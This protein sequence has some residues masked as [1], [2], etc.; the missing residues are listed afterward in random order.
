MRYFSFVCL[1]A[2][3]AMLPDSQAAPAP[4]RIAAIIDAGSDKNIEGVLEDVVDHARVGVREHP[5]VS[6]LPI[7]RQHKKNLGAWLKKNLRLERIPRT[8]RVYVRFR[9]GNQEEQAAIINAIVD[10]YLKEIVGKRRASF[11]HELNTYK[12]AS[13]AMRRRGKTIDL[14]Q[15]AKDIKKREERVRTLPALVEHAKSR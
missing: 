5:E 6:K 2:F 8:N 10:S 7:V 12:R 14:V 13:D 3:V 1:F 4:K 11:I 15:E 9:E